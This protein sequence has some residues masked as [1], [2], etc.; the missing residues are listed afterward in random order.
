MYCE[1]FN[2]MQ[3]IQADMEIIWSPNTTQRTTPKLR[4]T[5]L[6]HIM[7]HGLSESDFVRDFVSIQG[8]IRYQR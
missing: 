5:K 7:T 4:A 6:F 3:Q 2:N 8:V 1:A